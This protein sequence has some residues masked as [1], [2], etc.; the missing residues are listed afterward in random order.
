MILNFLEIIWLFST[1]I[2][3]EGNNQRLIALANNLILHTLT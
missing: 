1:L 3:L 2:T